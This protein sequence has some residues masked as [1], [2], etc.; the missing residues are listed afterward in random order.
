M[1]GGGYRRADVSAFFG[2]WMLLGLGTAVKLLAGTV[3]N[4]TFGESS[5]GTASP[6]SSIPPAASLAEGSLR[7]EASSPSS[8]AVPYLRQ[9]VEEAHG[10][11]DHEQQVD[12]TES[13][14]ATPPDKL[15]N[16]KGK[17]GSG[18][19]SGQLLPEE[20]VPLWFVQVMET[21][22]AIDRDGNGLIAAAELRQVLTDSHLDA[23]EE[24]VQGMVVEAD[25]NGDSLI[26]DNE[27][28]GFAQQRIKSDFV[29]AVLLAT[30]WSSG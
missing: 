22:Q 3:G 26:D 2:V 17:R 29:W 4:S 11:E 12:K 24:S 14:V 5:S 13:K 10:S 18:K 23:T 30:G 8:L 1:Q 9:S 27:L 15:G 28:A 16:G 20:Q 19:G 6:S 25:A 7:E 21:F